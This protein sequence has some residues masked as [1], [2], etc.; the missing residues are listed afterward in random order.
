M[1]LIL[2]KQPFREMAAIEYEKAEKE[3]EIFKERHKSILKEQF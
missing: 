1:K 3:Y 2:E